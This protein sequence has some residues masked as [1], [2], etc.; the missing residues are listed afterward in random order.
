MYCSESFET[1]LFGSVF[2][3]GVL[4]SM[5]VLAFSSKYGR[6]INLVISSIITCGAVYLLVF[7]NNVYA[8]YFGMFV[9][10]CWFIRNIQSYIIATELSPVRLQ[11]VVT[12]VILGV[13][14]L[15]IPIC[16]LYFKFVNNEWKYVT[17]VIIVIVSVA[18]I[19]AMFVPESPLFLYEKEEYDRARAIINS[20]ARING[21][22]LKNENWRFDKEVVLTSNV[23]LPVFYIKL[24]SSVFC[25]YI[26]IANYLMHCAK[27]IL[28]TI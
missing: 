16:S 21:S 23:L 28:I 8:R 2:F 15:T 6:R 3:A 24:I 19:A 17:Y 9:L 26:S 11:I 5:T 7:V 10:G 4:V 12:S 1:S 18:T 22:S 14:V 25:N 13:D 20:I 27:Q